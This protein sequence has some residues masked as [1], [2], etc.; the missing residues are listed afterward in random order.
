[1]VTLIFYPEEKR[2]I[3]TERLKQELNYMWIQRTDKAMVKEKHI[4]ITFDESQWNNLN[5]VQQETI[6]FV[7]DFNWEF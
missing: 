2:Y 3:N 5:D 4:A 7:F 1:M 6:K